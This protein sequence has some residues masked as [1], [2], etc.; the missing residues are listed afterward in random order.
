MINKSQLGNL[1]L[2]SGNTRPS[3]AL[4]FCYQPMQT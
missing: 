4:R 2:S 3:F 1:N